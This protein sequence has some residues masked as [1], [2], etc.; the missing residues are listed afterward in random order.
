M[1]PYKKIAEVI[2]NEL[3]QFKDISISIKFYDYNEEKSKKSEKD[4]KKSLPPSPAGLYTKRKDKNKWPS[5]IDDHQFIVVISKLE[6]DKRFNKRFKKLVNA[7]I[8]WYF[9][10]LGIEINNRVLL[11]QMILHELGHVEA[12]RLFYT[13]GSNDTNRS[14]YRRASEAILETN[15]GPDMFFKNNEDYGMTL[16]YLFG[17]EELFAEWFSF[18]NFY[19]VWGKVKDLK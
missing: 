17:G 8:G 1:L 9:E 5:S 16:D 2:L 7:R 4:R 11:T 12:T 14:S 19:R 13:G 18:R 15:F 3:P 10:S 6:T